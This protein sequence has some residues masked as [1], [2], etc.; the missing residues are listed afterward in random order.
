MEKFEAQDTVLPV[1]SIVS[2]LEKHRDE[3][4]RQ[5][6]LQPWWNLKRRW[7]LGGAAAAYQY[8]INAVLEVGGAT[9]LH[10]L[11]NEPGLTE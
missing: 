11:F 5:I 2:R 7:I 1:S 8:E 10:Y 3:M 6:K 4:L 9:V